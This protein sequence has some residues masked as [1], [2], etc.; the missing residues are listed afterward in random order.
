[1]NPGAYPDKIK[2]SL[3]VFDHLF[4]EFELNYVSAMVPVKSAKEYDA[5]LDVAVLF[6]ES[7]ER[8]I[9]AGYV[10]R[11]QIEDCDPTVMITVPRLAIVCGLLIYPLGALNVDRPPDQLSE[12]FRPFQTLL[13][14]IRSCNKPGP[15]AILDLKLQ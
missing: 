7:L 6:S 15:A 11:E 10:T 12:M 14:K 3:R 1:R 8:A 2:T 9:K 4:A 13:G 5:Q